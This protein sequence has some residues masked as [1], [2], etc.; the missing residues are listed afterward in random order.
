MRSRQYKREYD[1]FSEHPLAYLF[2]KLVD[3]LKRDHFHKE[4]D[5]LIA[6]SEKYY[7]P[8]NNKIITKIII[9]MQRSA[10]SDET[11]KFHQHLRELW[12]S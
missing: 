7:L 2:F 11:K 1:N 6:I 8:E 4:A 9:G 10:V 12:D 5:D 3:M